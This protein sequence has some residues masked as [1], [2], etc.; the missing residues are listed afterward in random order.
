ML[1]FLKSPKGEKSLTKINKNCRNFW[2]NNS[3]LMPFVIHQC[4]AS[5]STHFQLTNLKFYYF[6]LFFFIKEEEQEL[7]CFNS[8]VWLKKRFDWFR[9]DIII[10]KQ[11][12]SG[13]CPKGG[14]STSIQQS[15]GSKL[16]TKSFILIQGQMCFPILELLV[17]MYK[18]YLGCIFLRGQLNSRPRLKSWSRTTALNFL[19]SAQNLYFWEEN[20]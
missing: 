3:I 1:R 19:E 12:S 11:L 9:E 2:T 17:P 7:Y 16:P 18:K 10:K 8:V 5:W 14:C 4:G 20:C 13:S 6:P 15:W